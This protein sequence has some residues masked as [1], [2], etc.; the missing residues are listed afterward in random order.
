MLVFHAG[1][2][3]ENKR[4]LTNGGRVL[5]IT[6]FGENLTQAIANAYLGVG[7]IH[8][9]GAYFRRD[10][11]QKALRQSEKLQNNLTLKNISDKI[12]EN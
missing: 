4:V 7:K 12:S 9:E 2:I 6:G 8:F 5:N 1:T 3:N 10:I 11:G